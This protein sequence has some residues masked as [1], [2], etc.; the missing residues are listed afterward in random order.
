MRVLVWLS[1]WV[2]SAVAAY[3]LKQQGFDVVGGFMKNYVSDGWN[4]TTYDDAQEAIKVAKFL[5]IELLSFDLQKE[6]NDR[7]IQYIY[8]GYAKWVTPN[9]D[10]FCNSL[11]KFD[12][13]L[14]KALEMWFDKIAMWHYAKIEEKNNEYCLL[15]G[16][17]YNKDQSYFL[18]WLNQFQLSK[19]LLPLWWLTKQEVRKIAHDIQLPNADRPDSQGLCFIGN[20]PMK[21]FLEQKLPKKI[22]NIVTVDGKV[23]GQ[24]EWAWFYTLGQR[25]GLWINI[26]SYVIKTDVEKNLVIVWDK[27]H[28]DLSHSDLFALDWHWI[29]KKYD[30]PLDVKTK[31]RYRQ[32]PQPAQL[33]WF[34][35]QQL[36]IKFQESQWAIAS[37]QIVVAYIGDECIGSGI[38]K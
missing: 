15:R 3:V 29:G 34:E 33:V 26:K 19:A 14:D 20:I 28:E 21:K 9:P 31:I 2:D 36:H 11:I 1:W 30:F 27:S 22:W 37:W 16:V 25:H 38:I 35:H 8:D 18:S 12:V 4:C 7:I 17:D 24:H 32:E 23:L 13:F 5:G 6:Y 10:V